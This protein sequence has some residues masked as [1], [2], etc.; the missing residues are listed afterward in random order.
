MVKTWLIDNDKET[1]NKSRVYKE[2]NKD[3]GDW[4][5]WD[6]EKR[7]ID[8]DNY[9]ISFVIFTTGETVIIISYVQSKRFF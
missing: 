4:Y 1:D 8:N 5:S 9:M 6:W 3:N 7:I 2:N